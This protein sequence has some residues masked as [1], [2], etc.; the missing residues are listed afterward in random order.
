MTDTL[1]SECRQ[2]IRTMTL[3]VQT[4]HNLVLLLW[5]LTFLAGLGLAIWGAITGHLTDVRML[6]P[7]ALVWQVAL[8]LY[9]RTITNELREIVRADAMITLAERNRQVQVAA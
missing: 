8:V 1:V 6:W 5:V 2:E 4:H 7:I 3:T 9:G